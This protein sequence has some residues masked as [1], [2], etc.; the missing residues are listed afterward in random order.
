MITIFLMEKGKSFICRFGILIKSVRQKI[1]FAQI[2][3]DK[4]LIISF[5]TDSDFCDI[6]FFRELLNE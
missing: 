2:D 1:F 5:Q 3:S 6:I 4:F